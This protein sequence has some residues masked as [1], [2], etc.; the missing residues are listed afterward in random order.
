VAVQEVVE[1]LEEGEEAL[2]GWEALGL[3]LVPVGNVSTPIAEPDY[4]IR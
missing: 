2:G 4:H 1:V 3:E